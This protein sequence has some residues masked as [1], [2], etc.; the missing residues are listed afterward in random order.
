SEFLTQRQFRRTRL[1]AE[2]FEPAETNFLLAV[3]LPVPGS[4][5]VGFSLHRRAGDFT[6]R[7]RE[8][9]DLVQPHLASAYERSLL[10]ALVGSLA[11]AERAE[12]GLVVLALDGRPLW[13]T[14]EAERVIERVFGDTW[15]TGRLPTRVTEWLVGGCRGPLVVSGGGVCVRLDAVGERPVALV[16]GERAARPALEVLVGL[17]LTRREA[18]VLALVAEGRTNAQ[19]ARQLSVSPGTVKRHLERIYA[20]LGV[21]RRTEAAAAAWAAV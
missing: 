5:V 17:G 3:R 16:V 6:K 2:V 8:A 10:Q 21:H 7:D 13:V 20:K 9:V 19:V 14:P 1:F 12:P 4:L 11:A 15:R 18:E